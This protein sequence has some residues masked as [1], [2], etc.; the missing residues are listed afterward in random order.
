MAVGVSRQNP[1]KQGL[2][3]QTPHR[4]IAS[5]SRLNIAALIL[6]IIAINALGLNFV[7]I[8]FST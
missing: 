6:K 3:I 1:R 5:H 4:N 7:I 2:C 8:I